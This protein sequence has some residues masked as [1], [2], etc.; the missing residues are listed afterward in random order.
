MTKTKLHLG[1]GRHIL[2][3]Y[4][5]VDR[6]ALTGVDVIHDLREFPWPFDDAQ[7]KEV[8][9]VDIVEHLPDTL[10]TMEEF[11]RIVK[12]QGM[13]H[14]RVPYFNSLDA[15]GDPTHVRSFNENSFDFFDSTTEVHSKRSYYTQARFRIIAIGYIIYLLGRPVILV[16][17]GEVASKIVLPPPYNRPIVSCHILKRIYSHAAHKFGNMINALHV[18]LER[19]P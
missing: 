5:N 13:V 10:R 9:A 7:F 8:I 12:P 16:D 4:V 17:H 1:C 3:E 18:T 2:E 19:S 15:S 11:F 14:I 6:I